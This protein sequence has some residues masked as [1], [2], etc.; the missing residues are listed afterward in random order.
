MRR[1]VREEG[2]F[3]LPLPL[4]Y[5]MCARCK[6]IIGFQCAFDVEDE[7][8]RV[9]MKFM[10]QDLL[11]VVHARIVTKGLGC[12]HAWDLVQLSMQHVTRIGT[13]GRNLCFGP[14]Y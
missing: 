14:E 13:I 9:P 7:K 5:F 12:Q 11:A 1:G 10:R 4:V 8:R 2:S 6:T 3:K